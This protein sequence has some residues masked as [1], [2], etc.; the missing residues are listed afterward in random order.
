MSDNV[1]VE[2][3]ALMKKNPKITG[4]TRENLLQAFWSL[5]RQK[6]IEHITI[7]DITTKAGYN[8]STFYEYFVDIY[9]VLNRLED[10]AFGRPERKSS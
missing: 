2:E 3:S 7:Q 1:D 8:R 5:Y 9:D 4:Q 10:F 6:K